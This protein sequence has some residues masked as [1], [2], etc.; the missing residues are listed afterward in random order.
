MSIFEAIA[1]RIR[2][3]SE[4]ERERA[5][6]AYLALL[7]RLNEPG[8]EE[9]D[10]DAVVGVLEAAGKTCSE[11]EADFVRYRELR[12]LQARI[13]E[14]PRVEAELAEAV[15]AWNEAREE[16]DRC[17]KELEAVVARCEAEE[18][19]LNGE[20]D[21]LTRLEDR[22]HDLQRLS[23][24]EAHLAKE[25]KPVDGFAL[26]EQAGELHHLRWAFFADAKASA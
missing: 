13:A 15:L 23:A 4:E 25:G 11:F 19:L 17:L 22:C 12:E 1:N 20:L 21:R 16:R 6:T 3:R 2:V 7:E 24:L 10:A 18:G 14:R 8:A 5:Q 26:R 9:P